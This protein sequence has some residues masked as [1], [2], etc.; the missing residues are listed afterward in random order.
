LKSVIPEQLMKKVGSSRKFGRPA[1]LGGLLLAFVVALGLGRPPATAAQAR[2]V[3][4]FKVDPLWPKP[5]PAPKDANGVPHQWV[6]GQVGGN[7]VDSHDHTFAL[8]RA[9]QQ[10]PGGKLLAREGKT[11]IP[12]PAVI[13]YD[14]EGNLVNSWGDRTIAPPRRGTSDGPSAVM[15]ESMHGCF[16]DYQDNVWI[17]GYADGVVQKYTHD[18]KTILLQIGTKGMCDGPDTLSPRRAYPTCGTPGTNSSHTLLDEPAGIAV[19]PAP[20]PV[21]GQ[22]GDVYIA[23]GYGNHRVVVFDSKGKYLRQFGSAGRGDG[24]FQVSDGGHPHC[25][26]LGNDNLVYACDRGQDRIE[27]F[28]K[29]GNFKRHI[30]VKPPAGRPTAIV[31]S[32][33]QAQSFMYVEDSGNEAIWV[34]DRSLGTVL[35]GFGRGG[36]A[37]GEFT[38]AHTLAGDSKGNLYV[39]ETGDGRRIQKFVLQH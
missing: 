38:S 32:P 17:G 15:P 3:P 11:S 36:H 31:F 27:V 33:D 37:P 39:A 24:Q 18:G 26:V 7:C 19:D 28:D 21:T 12:A 10:G 35:G 34:M 5:L 6:T 30:L 29:M 16:V 9:F 20:D 13:E 23:D 4:Q 8:N 2:Q 1:Y 25:V 22:A 14:P